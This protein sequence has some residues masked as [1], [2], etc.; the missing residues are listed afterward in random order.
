MALNYW[1]NWLSNTG[2][3]APKVRTG[4]SKI[5]GRIKIVPYFGN[6][7]VCDIKATD[8]RKWQNEPIKKGYSQ[9]YLKTINNQLCAIFNYAVKYYD[10]SSNPY[11][12][13][14]QNKY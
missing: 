11:I 5:A 7:R 13:T 12:R 2:M 9:T 8:I 14:P 1:N 6:K 10:L 4:G 3:V